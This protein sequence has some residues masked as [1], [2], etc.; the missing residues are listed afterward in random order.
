MLQS[1]IPI[2]D[3]SVVEQSIR[4]CFVELS[5]DPNVNVRY[6]SG[7]ALWACDQDGF[8]DDSMRIIGE[9]RSG[10]TKIFA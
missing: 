7:E 3:H 9:F 10:I 8:Q 1:L 5:E 6:F 4:P 2:I